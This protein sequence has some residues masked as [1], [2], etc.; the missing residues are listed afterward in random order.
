MASMPSYGDPLSTLP[1]FDILAQ[2]VDDP[3][4]FVTRNPRVLNAWE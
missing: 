1:I 2:R 3:C 4:D